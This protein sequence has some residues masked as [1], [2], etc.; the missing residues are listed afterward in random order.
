[1]TKDELYTLCK[2]RGNVYCL[3]KYFS[4]HFLE[5]YIELK[6]FN[7]PQSFKFSQKLYHY[8]NNDPELKLGLCPVCGKRCTFVNINIGYLKHC[9]KRCLGLDENIKEQRKKSCLEKYGVDNYSKTNECKEKVKATN[10]KL[11]GEE[12]YRQTNEYK[13]RVKNTCQEKYNNDTYLGSKVYK[14]KV[15]QTC[16]R[17]YGETSYSSVFQ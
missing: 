4:K 10:K 17:K 1:M 2:E 8:F 3:E 5:F 14:E 15:K 7:F 13:D 9:S 6:T 11:Y 12:Y 16:I